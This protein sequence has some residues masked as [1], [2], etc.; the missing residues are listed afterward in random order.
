M[1]ETERLLLRPW[2][3]G[4]QAALAAVNGDPRV[5]D[6][7][8][9]P[10]DRAASDALFDRLVAHQAKY[11]FCAWAAERKADGRILGLIGLGVVTAESLP[12]GPAVEMAW[13]LSP[14]AWGA[15][16]ATEGA[17][18]ALDW[19]FDNLDLS[20][21]IAFTARTNLRSQAVMR[22]IG[23]QA[24]PARDFD[25]PRVAADS[26]LRPHVVFAIPRPAS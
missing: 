25:H 3:E 19:G 26:P 4:E 21:I 24:D 15:G 20:E 9:G 23:M 8:G 13:R 14:D 5:S 16:Y 12:V 7:L 6:W 10:I 1:I 11:G 22:R 18:A 2:R 17:Q